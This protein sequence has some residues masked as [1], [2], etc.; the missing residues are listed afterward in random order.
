M[1]EKLK[2]S[3][4]LFSAR[5]SG[6]K[7]G[8]NAVPASRQWEWIFST[9]N[10]RKHK[11]HL[12]LI[13]CPPAST[14]SLVIK[15]PDQ[16]VNKEEPWEKDSS[17]FN[18]NLACLGYNLVNPFVQAKNTVWQE[19]IPK[20]WPLCNFFLNSPEGPAQCRTHGTQLALHSIPKL[21]SQIWEDKYLILDILSPFCTKDRACCVDCLDFLK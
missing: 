12:P 1:L 2:Q 4:L 17:P 15:V 13:H 19:Q 7:A 16:P 21:S 18:S 5:S 9:K 11:C 6:G 20:H 14:S 3:I 8:E 10:F